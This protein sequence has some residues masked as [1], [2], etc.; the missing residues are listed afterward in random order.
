MSYY[1]LPNNHNNMTVDQ[2][3][4]KSSNECGFEAFISKS[5]YKYVYNVKGQIDN[6]PLQWD[7]YKKYTNPY[8]YIHTQ[9]PNYTSPIAKYKPL[10]RSYFKFIEIAKLLHIMDQFSF[11]N[12]KS[13]HFAEGP[14]GFIEAIN[15]MR[16]NIRDRYFGMTLINENINVPGWKKSKSFLETHPNIFLEKGQTGDGDLYKVENLK[17]CFSNYGNSIDLITGDGGF[18]FSVNYNEQEILSSKLILVQIIY[19]LMLQ[20]K[21]GVFILKIFDTFCKASV[22]CVYLLST[23]YNQVYIVKP[24]TSRYANSERYLVCRDFKYANTEHFLSTF[25]QIIEDMKDT[26]YVYNVLDISIPYNF[27]CKIEEINAIFGQQQIESIINTINLIEH[28]KTEKI[29]Q[30]KKNN[31]QKCINWCSKYNV[32]YNKSMSQHNIFLSREI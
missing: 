2:L 22:Q 10:S 23:F 25:C 16:S 19:G 28:S 8:E 26:S 14:G 21:G 6:Y 29:E 30:I 13:F 15:N 27:I 31:I 20:K 17:H 18:D 3:N 5:L 4:V 32:P 12:I 24:N 7:N 11:K 9:V 1:L